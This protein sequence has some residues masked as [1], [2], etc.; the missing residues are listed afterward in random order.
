[1]HEKSDDKNVRTCKL[2]METMCFR[3]EI[4]ECPNLWCHMGK[5]VLKLEKASNGVDVGDSYTPL[6]V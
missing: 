1:M 5:E 4:S 2:L 6:L 3:M